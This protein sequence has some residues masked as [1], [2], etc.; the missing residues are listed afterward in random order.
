[1]I[2]LLKS[3]G[4]WFARLWRW[5]WRW[6]RRLSEQEAQASLEALCRR[7]SWRFSVLESGRLVV[8]FRLKGE[9]PLWRLEYRGFDFVDAV[10][11]VL[12]R[13]E[14]DLQRLQELS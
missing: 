12:K 4:E 7:R 2:G 11:L 14:F 1:M 13:S 5:L 9:R 10:G 8:V 3:L 6:R